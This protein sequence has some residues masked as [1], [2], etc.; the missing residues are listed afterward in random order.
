MSSVHVNI[1]WIE[2][3]KFELDYRTFKVVVKESYNQLKVKVNY[4]YIGYNEQN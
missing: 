1:F 2:H 4:N 3:S